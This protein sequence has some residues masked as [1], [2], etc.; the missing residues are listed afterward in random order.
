[1]ATDSNALRK[2]FVT[3]LRN[4]HAME[5]QANELLERQIERLDDYPELKTR[6]KSHLEE[7]HR[8]QERLDRILG[9]L[10]ESASTIKDTAMSLFGNLAAAGHMPA[11]SPASPSRIT[12][13]PPINL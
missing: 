2:I 7:T 12:K 4:A 1:M 10:G 6:L 11:P 8:Q 5:A 9:G 13:Q 3:G